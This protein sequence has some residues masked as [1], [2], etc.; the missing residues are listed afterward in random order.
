VALQAALAGFVEAGAM[1]CAVEASSIGLAEHRLAGTAIAVAAFTNFTHDH[2]DYH[3]DMAAYWAAKRRL[4]EWP[5]L[6]AAVVNT[7]DE[8]GALLAAELT[9]ASASSPDLWTCS[10]RA[11][12]RLQGSLLRYVGG[13]LAFDVVEGDQRHAVHSA[14]IGEHN[15][16][17]LLGVIGVLRALGV[18]LGEATQAMGLLEPV[19]GRLQQ[20]PAASDEAPLAIVDYAH[21]PD[22]LE[23]ALRALRPLAAS[24][25]G[26]LWCVFG[27]GGDRDP[28]KRPLMGAIAARDA[29]HVVLSSDNPRS[30]NA[31]HI[32]AQILVGM[33]REE[34]VDVIE[35]R[36]A[37]IRHALLSAA[38]T[39]VVLIAGKGHEDYQEVAGVKR[40]FSDLA[41]AADVLRECAE[42]H[43]GLPP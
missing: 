40:P 19:P 30:E 38:A 41:V 5:G 27:C 24:R 32:L 34:A 9:A 11:G 10:L 2:L 35:D 26:A 15:A 13:A 25:G 28:V 1:A 22:A 17:N 8:Q 16:H 12:A 4:F 43:A 23:K 3:A 6:R 18:P 7:D 37:A 21:T 33:P 31:G 20:V 29:D 36:A 42:Q 39:D 14:L